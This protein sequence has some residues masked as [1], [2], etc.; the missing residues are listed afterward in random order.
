M[1]RYLL[2]MFSAILCAAPVSASDD[3]DR[4]DLAY[5]LANTS[6]IWLRNGPD[7]DKDI[8]EL[9]SLLGPNAVYLRA[10]SGL[11]LDVPVSEAS[12][13]LAEL[14]THLASQRSS[15]KLEIEAIEPNVPAYGFAEG[16]GRLKP[17]TA[18]A[19]QEIPPG[20]QRVT[21]PNGFAQ[22]PNTRRVW[23]IDSG[24]AKDY[25]G[26]ELNVDRT[27]AR[28]CTPACVPDNE[29]ID[30]V[31]H[32][33]ALAG[34]IG[35]KNNAYGFVGVAPGVTLVPV[36]VFPESNTIT[37]VSAIFQALDYVGTTANQNDVVNLSLGIEWDPGEALQPTLETKI[38]DLASGPKKLR[39]AIAAGNRRA[40]D[41][42]YV[43]QIVP[44][45]IGGFVSGTG[46]IVT[47]S[48]VNSDDEWWN[49]SAYGNSLDSLSMG[50]DALP[51]PPNYAEPGRNIKTL[52][53]GNR[54][55]RCTGT[56]FAAAHMSGILTEGKPADG[57]KVIGDPSAK[58]PRTGVEDPAKVEEVGI[59]P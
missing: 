36:Q 38:R 50:V 1:G 23:I 22:F 32:G 54:S 43:Q 47:V 57:G 19:P 53:P 49:G 20:V 16:C 25:D 29:Q 31:G 7:G 14:Q 45:R 18:V 8:S 48:A 55:A 44:A 51:G 9:Q 52:W 37:D 46:M 11:I 28:T 59:V 15:I 13:K 21:T 17:V 35:A 27:L 30:V 5:R 39:F 24:I 34:I 26:S 42:S 12:R 40:V 10:L 58:D 56:S 4:N 41:A 6:I 33:T 3:I 2:L